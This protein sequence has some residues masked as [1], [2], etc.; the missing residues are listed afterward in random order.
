MQS[1]KFVIGSLVYN[2]QLGLGKVI[3]IFTNCCMVMFL[4]YANK[5]LMEYESLKIV[6]ATEVFKFKINKIISEEVNK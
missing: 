1:D 5:L 4:F 3:E 6:N 2:N